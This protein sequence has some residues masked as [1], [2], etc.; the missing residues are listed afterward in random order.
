[1]VLLGAHSGAYFSPRNEWEQLASY[2]RHH[3]IERLDKRAETPMA[4][5]IERNANY[6]PRRDNQSDQFRLPSGAYLFTGDESIQAPWV[7]LVPRPAY[8]QLNDEII[9]PH[10]NPSPRIKRGLKPHETKQ[11][12]GSPRVREA[13]VF[14][15][16][17]G[18]EWRSAT[19]DAYIPPAEGFVNLEVSRCAEANLRRISPGIYQTVFE[20]GK[21]NSP[22][23]MK[24]AG[25]KP[26]NSGRK[27]SARPL[28]AVAADGEDQP[29]KGSLAIGR[30]EA[31]AL[32][33]E[34]DRGIIDEQ[35]HRVMVHERLLAPHLA[36][37]PE[38]PPPYRPPGH[39]LR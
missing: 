3:P 10:L 5:R 37:P 31:R 28:A 1:M 32:L 4:E 34:L 26:L 30:R 33:R 18:S 38:A 9:V 13:A 39:E 17:F 15:L 25:L 2:S 14:D 29:K 27:L 24:H 23:A 6:S 35:A 36:P 19:A 7:G 12:D 20:R 11:K 21:M 22:R 16:G 8:K